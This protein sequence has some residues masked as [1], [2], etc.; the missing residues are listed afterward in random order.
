MAA[1]QPRKGQADMKSILQVSKHA[2]DALNQLIP[3]NIHVE[4]AAS[5]P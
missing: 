3:V 2:D 4:W 5:N 1:S